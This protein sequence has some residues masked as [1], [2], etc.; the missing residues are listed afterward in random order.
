MTLT[1]ADV[2]ALYPLIV[3]G[4][5]SALVLL[6]IA[7]RRHH[8]LSASLAAAGFV[9][10]LASTAALS[11]DLPRSV[12][13]LL[14]MD[15]ASL[16][17]IRLLLAAGLA[18]ALLAYPYLEQLPGQKEEFYVLL[19]IASLGASVLAASTHFTSFFLGLEILTVSL[20]GMIAYVRSSDRSLEA[21]I[22]YLILAAVSSAFILFGMALVYAETGSMEFIRAISAADARPLLLAAGYGMILVGAG[23]KL[24]VA[25][26]HLW[27]PD[28][29]EGA[30]APVTA[31]IATVSKGAVF[32]VLLRLLPVLDLR[33][34]SALFQALSLAAVLSMFAGNL[35]ALL[36]A[37]VK[38]MLAYSSIA[39]AGY[40]LVALLAGGPSG[41]FAATFYL[42][43]YIIT[44]LGTFGVV[45]VLS[46]SEG[47]AV[48]PSDYQG[49]AW[50]RPWLA[51]TFIAMLLSLAGM[52]LTAGFVG[53]F[54][55]AAVGVGSSLWLLVASLVIGSVIGLFY[56]LRL[57]VLLF[58]TESTETPA[59]PS[60]TLGSGG[61][62]AALLFL[63]LWIGSAPGTMIQLVS[64]AMR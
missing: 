19:L 41:R 1:F 33:P 43:A 51:A 32:A 47:D 15:P 30:P 26:F 57:I 39:H 61:V 31:F 63:L 37:N 10:A 64:R 27:T 56:Y 42:V 17:Y 52:P 53:K 54:S 25:P 8:A 48:S 3:T 11:A 16:F 7:V 50:R 21:G 44:T 22:K 12:T 40:I 38:R 18:V 60:R 14:I 46:R 29:Y 20:Y 34:G 59:L 35:L 45:T 49:L 55:L 9:L 28:V 13:G 23:F 6:T 36:Q 2:I 58:S 5:A 62:L 24:A 4:A